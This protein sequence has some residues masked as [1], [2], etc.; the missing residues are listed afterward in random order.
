MAIL[1]RKSNGLEVNVTGEDLLWYLNSPYTSGKYNILEMT[2]QEYKAANPKLLIP[3]NVIVKRDGRFATCKRKF[4]SSWQ[5]AGY[6]LVGDAEA[7]AKVEEPKGVAK[8]SNPK[9]AKVNATRAAMAV[10]KG[11]GIDPATVVGTGPDGKI[12]KADAEA[13][14]ERKVTGTL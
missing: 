13:A 11:A 8:A 10:L 3:G 6:V 5:Q 2:L 7:S 14:A 4:L 12:T 1:K 9:S